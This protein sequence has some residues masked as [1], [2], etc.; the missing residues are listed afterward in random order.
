[1]TPSEPVSPIQVL[2]TL[3]GYWRTIVLCT[4]VVL[5][6]AIAAALLATP[7]YRSEALLSYNEDEMTD[8]GLSG[9]V[10]QL[11]GL[12]A[13]AGLGLG[14]SEG[15]KAA[16]LALLT[17]HGFLETFIRDKDLLPT[18]F[19]GQWNPEDQT[20]VDG[21]LSTPPTVADGVRLLRERVLAVA[22]DRRTGLVRVSVEWTD[23]EIAA[24]WANEFVRRANEETRSWAISEARS[25]Q[26]YLNAELEKADV[27]ELRQ[28]INR[29]IEAELQKE[30]MAS[31]RMQYSFRVID[32]AR[33][34][35]PDDFVSPRR[36]RLVA[37]GLFAGLGA[38]LLTA[39][40]LN[41]LRRNSG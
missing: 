22:E 3:G 26:E 4:V 19:S 32:E 11:S 10:S 20:W 2:R 9:A 1:M 6:L 35:D 12:S 40:V 15:Q 41:A 16:A 5:S 14:G 29:L 18:L 37:F 17:S 38:G 36:L 34:S 39:L 7:Q 33:A 24:E 28:S 27:L 21:W 13:I 25:S 30:M 31:V 8:A 23:P